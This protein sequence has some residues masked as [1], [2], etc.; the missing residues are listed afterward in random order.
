MSQI[1]MLDT[2]ICSFIM[3]EHPRHVLER[4]QACVNARELM[5]I[6][7]GCVPDAFPMLQ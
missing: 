4:M 2:N 1:Y 5:V 6:D 3:R 7:G